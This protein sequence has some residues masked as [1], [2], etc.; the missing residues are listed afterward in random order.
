MRWID[1]I[2]RQAEEHPGW[3]SEKEK[4]HVLGQFAEAR[5]ILAERAA[6]D[7]SR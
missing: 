6:Q 5:K 7:L 4:A 1:A 3:R 2:T